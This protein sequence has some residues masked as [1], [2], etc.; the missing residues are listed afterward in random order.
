MVNDQLNNF[1]IGMIWIDQ[2]STK[3][4]QARK[5]KGAGNRKQAREQE[6]RSSSKEEQAW[7]SKEE[8]AWMSINLI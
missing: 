6:Q 4:E 7:M 1:M 2:G 5:S 3:Q 8:Q